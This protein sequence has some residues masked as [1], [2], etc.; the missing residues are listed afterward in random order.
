MSIFKDDISLNNSL[1]KILTNNFQVKTL[2]ENTDLEKNSPCVEEF[3]KVVL[4]DNIQTKQNYNETLEKLQEDKSLLETT[5]QGLSLIYDQLKDIKTQIKDG[6]EK[7]LSQED[8][9]KTNKAIKKD[10]D[11][12]QNIVENTSFND[13]KPLKESSFDNKKN[14]VEDGD[15]NTESVFEDASSKTIVLPKIEEVSM[16]TKEEYNDFLEKM[17][18]VTDKVMKTQ[19]QIVKYEEKLI[20][21]VDNFI[22]IESNLNFDGLNSE[23]VNLGKELKETAINGIIKDPETGKK[24][25]I[26]SLDENLLLALFSVS[27]VK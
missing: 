26:R 16:K 1:Q 19:E 7:P 15:L 12:I 24:I 11:N 20:K 17:D 6:L 18:K 9:E 27:R 4:S 22:E 14:N 5:K 10:L 8:I 2:K 23:N 13:V 21:K 25:Q 3:E